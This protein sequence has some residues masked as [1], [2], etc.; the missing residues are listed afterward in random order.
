M[1][2]VTVGVVMTLSFPSA[3]QRDFSKVEIETTDLGSGLA[4]LKGAGGNVGVS[5]G[6]D[7]VLLID[8]QYA[9]LTEKILA[10]VHRLSSEPIRFLLN[11]HWHGDH[12]GGNENL[13]RAG[14]LIFAHHRVR[15]RLSTEQFQPR[16]GRTIPPSAE[17]AWPVV[18]FEDGV[19]FHLNGQTIEVT[20][21]APAHTD[22]DSI[23][24]F[25]EADVLHMGDA[26]FSGMYPFIDVA[27]GGRVG[28]MIDA[29][30]RGLAIAGP[31]TRIIPGHGPLSGRKELLAF[32]EM[33]I[34]LR[35]RVRKMIEAGLGRDEVVAAKPSDDF[36]EAFGGGFFT[37]DRFVGI[38]YDALLVE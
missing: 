9:P 23:V 5:V 17:A 16:R 36:D 25:R 19:T 34:S 8:D 13:G 35:D 33:L 12:T 38:V 3:A 18:T 20:H 27:S 4:M 30:D 26:F 22:G 6:P 28:G 11:T 31:E 21:V 1:R 7:G 15:E 2:V 10:A 37:P 14:V 24:Y 29:A 32:R